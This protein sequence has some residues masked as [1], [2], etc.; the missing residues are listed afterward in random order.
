MARRTHPTTM[1]FIA[2]G[3]HTNI[4][5]P[6]GFGRVADDCPTACAELRV[7]S[8]D[9]GRSRSGEVVQHG[10]TRV[11]SFSGLDLRLPIDPSDVLVQLAARAL[12]HFLKDG[13]AAPETISLVLDAKD[14][15]YVALPAVAF[16]SWT[17][18]V[19]AHLAVLV[20]ELHELDEVHFC[21]SVRVVVKSHPSEAPMQA[22]RQLFAAAASG[23]QAGLLR[24]M[25]H[26]A[27]L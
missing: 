20:A 18:E 6:V 27:S 4:I 22:D 5:Q 8:R 23:T 1:S 3:W 24:T 9:E 12:F 14:G 15:H 19:A 2:L 17:T 26:A 21:R 7:P 13:K 10:H 11:Y 25:V 16:H